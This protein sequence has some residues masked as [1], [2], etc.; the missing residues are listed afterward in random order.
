VSHHGLFSSSFITPFL[1]AL[2]MTSKLSDHFLR[3]ALIDAVRTVLHVPAVHRK[4]ATMNGEASITAL[5]LL[6]KLHHDPHPWDDYWRTVAV[7]RP[8]RDAWWEERNLLPLL[9]RVEV[10]VY[11]GCDWQNVPLHL[12]STFPAFNALTNSKHVRVAM[13]GDYGLTWPWESLHVEALAWFDHWL[14]G[15]DT[16]ILEGPR[17]RY[18]LPEV[19]GFREADSWPLPGTT[20][21]ALALR[22]DGSLAEDEGDS[23]TRAMMTLGAGLNRDHA[24]E[25]DPPALLTWA[26]APLDRDLDMVGPIEMVLDAAA[27][28]MDTAFIAT[29]QDVDPSGSATDVTAGYLR[30]SLRDV[31]EAASA[32]GEPVLPCRAFQAVPVGQVV[33]YR[34]PLVDNARR[35]KAGHRIQLVLTG[36][37]QNP[38]APAIMGFRHASVGTSCHTIVHSS[39]RLLL[40]VSTG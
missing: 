31:D 39:S 30:A 3:S 28:A 13:L 19:E 37:D 25:T 40:P 7:E 1:S 10:P 23:G 36:D 18:V 12:P 27:S 33:R 20:H 32:P 35:F 5:K 16:G 29:L 22:A 2:G 38:D 24:S 17:I 26:S 4:F 21:R 8:L 11:L 34:I 14:K 9:H 6:M 15:K